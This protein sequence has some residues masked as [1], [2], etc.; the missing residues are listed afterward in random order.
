VT[1]IHL[2]DSTY[3]RVESRVNTSEFADADEY[4]EYVVNAVLD[5]IEEK[6]DGTAGDRNE[7]MD[8]LRDLGYLE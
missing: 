1:E 8:K 6:G 5:R 4:I 2:S 7:V 3:E